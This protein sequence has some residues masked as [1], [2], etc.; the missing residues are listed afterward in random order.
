[1]DQIDWLVA[2]S[3]D[4]TSGSVSLNVTHALAKLVIVPSFGTEITDKNITKIEIGGMYASG[5]LNIAD[6]TWSDLGTANA[7]LEMTNMELP[8]IPMAE[9]TEFTVTVTMQD[10]RVFKTTVSLAAVGNK[11][12]VGTQYNVALRVGQDK[13]TIGDITAAP[14]RNMY[15]GELATE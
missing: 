14:W 10:G 7:T 9:C 1:A 13:V 5:N 8:V 4:L 2:T 15:G 11:L 6:N 12:E 3:T